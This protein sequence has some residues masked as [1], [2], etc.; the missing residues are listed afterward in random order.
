M[1]LTEL[2]TDQRVM[3]CLWKSDNLASFMAPANRSLMLEDIHTL[4]LQS[5]FKVNQ[6]YEML[7][8]QVFDHINA[9]NSEGATKTV[10]GQTFFDNRLK[11]LTSMHH[12]KKLEDLA[13]LF[14]GVPALIIAAG[15]SLDKNIDQ[16]KKAVG[17]AIL[18]SVDT[19]LPNLL[20]H[21]ITPDFLTSIDY[22]EL[23]YEKIAGSASNP[24]VREINLICTSWVTDAV[25]KK[26]PAKNVFWAFND[27]PL[28]N[29]INISL[30]GKLAIAGAGTVAHLNFIAAQIMG[31][32]PIVFVGQDLAFTDSQGHS[33]NVVLTSTEAT[34]KKLDKGQDI[35]WVTGIVEAKVP[36]NRQMHGYKHV[37]EQLIK[38]SKGTIINSTEGGALIEGAENIPL[39]KAIGRFCKEKFNFNLNHQYSKGGKIDLR[40]SMESVVARIT[41]L[42]K[43]IQK[44][45]KL[46]EPL[47]KKLLDLK[48]KPRTISS[49]SGLP[50]KLRKKISDLDLCHK[51]ADENPLW[52]LFDE[53]TME[54]LRQ[55]ERQKQEI[56]TLKDIPGRYLDWLLKSLE[57]IDKVNKIRINNLERFKNQIND[58]TFYYTNENSSLE[59]I[60]KDR[61]NP[62]HILELAELYYQSENYVLLEKML[63]RYASDIKETAAIDYYYGII[64]LIR[65]DYADAENR[66]QSVLRCDDS[67]A[68]KIH[69]KRK[70]F[71]D[72]YFKLAKSSGGPLLN[73]IV[74]LLLLKGL[75]CC[76]DHKLIS[77]EFRQFGKN[78]LSEKKYQAALDH[79]HQALSLIHDDPDTYIT[80]ADIYFA[81]EDFDSGLK[82]LKAA[83]DLD[84]KYAVYWYNMGKNLQSQ[85]DYNGA[86]LAYEQYFIALPENISVLKEIGDCHT[87]L[88]NIE[89]A[90]ESYKQF[91]KMLNK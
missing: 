20:K 61:A 1:D 11:H 91:K 63:D 51:Q 71:A 29:W 54:G 6:A 74:A 82:Y 25:P 28:E 45:E 17:K 46:S 86:I 15:P 9:F 84:K 70:E 56:E 16:I 90:L 21:S 36:T 67:Y 12:D 53:M 40:Q 24:A 64:A 30:G 5:C 19:A 50:D 57:R 39:E 79:F 34:Q 26:F 88:G 59:R 18:I 8:S 75:R 62:D 42:E 89:A 7:S 78:L 22:K 38:A 4:N 48:K 72:H 35:M 65:E 68:E 32:D 13:E 73:P 44:A 37:F 27:N 87:K 10:Y 60:K 43:L 33:S 58:L 14:K 23:A 41:K 2:L 76:P 3:I 31:C 52:P 77:N 49:F 55:N 47:R 69:A 85:K 83:V 81:L 80:L 66:F